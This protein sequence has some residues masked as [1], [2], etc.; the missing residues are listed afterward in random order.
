MAASASASAS[1]ARRGAF[2]LLEGL[3][4]SGKS[5]QAKLLAEALGEAAGGA[6]H[7]QFPDRTTAVGKLL[8]AYLQNRAELDDR[9]VH[10][11]FSAN[12]WEASERMR[13]ALAAGKHLVVD[14]FSYSGV[15][16]SAAKGLELEW[17][18]APERGLPAPD[19]VVWLDLSPEEAQRR[20]G[21]GGERY[22]QA[23]FQARVREAF[24]R[25]RAREPARWRVVD[26]ARPV[27]EVHAAV[28][29]IAR[30]TA[31]AVATRPIERL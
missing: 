11:L 20:G 12:R 30:K 15:A 24:E 22:E 14:R 10:L 9:C 3:D 18:L 17:C 27:A 7:L 25:L 16:F 2:I 31:E 29:E 23:Q 4:R 28:A 19:V 6:V 26:A 1:A 13:G 5:S 21:F 8:D